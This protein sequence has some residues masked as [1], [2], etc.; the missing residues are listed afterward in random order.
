MSCTSLAES[1]ALRIVKPG[2]ES[3]PAAQRLREAVDKDTTGQAPTDE[4]RTGGFVIVDRT[5]VLSQLTSFIPTETLTIWLAV[6]TALG[7]PKRVPG[8]SV[9]KAEWAAHWWFALGIFLAT[10]GLTTALS[11]IKQK[12]ATPKARRKPFK[13][14]MPWPE[15]SAAG[16]GFAVWALSLPNTPL[17]TFCDFPADRWSPVIILG[18]TL[19]IATVMAMTGTSVNW[20]KVLKAK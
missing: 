19:A 4:A 15:V 13:F 9:C 17:Q 2:V 11:Y 6:L 1:S 16:A 5:A 12:E 20:A 7:D 3:S 8:Q 14:E 18:G 10:L